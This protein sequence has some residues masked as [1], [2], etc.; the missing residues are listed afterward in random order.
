MESPPYLVDQFA[1]SRGVSA[2]SAKRALMMQAFAAEGKTLASTIKALRISKDTATTIARRFMID[3]SDYRPYSSLEKRGQPRP[4]PF[5]RAD[6]PVDGL[7]LFA[8][9]A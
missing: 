5:Q 8:P 6:L 2:I 1:R 3:F 7:A 9:S 4:M